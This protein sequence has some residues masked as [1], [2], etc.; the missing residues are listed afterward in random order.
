MTRLREFNLPH[1]VSITGFLIV[2]ALGIGVS[3]VLYSS[4]SG[5]FSIMSFFSPELARLKYSATPLEKTLRTTM[6]EYVK[7][8]AD[9][10]TICR[11]LDSGSG[12]LGYYESASPIIQRDC[13]QCHGKVP[14]VAG[15]GSLYT[16]ADVLPY[17]MTRGSPIRKLSLRAH[18]HLFGIGL[19]LLILT[20]LANRTSI[21]HFL[22]LTISISLFGLLATDILSQ[23]LAKLNDAFA[24]IVWISGLLLNISVVI[25]ILLVLR[26][27]WFGE[28]VE[29]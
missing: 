23:Y 13:S 25:S 9:I 3:G 18:V 8:E 4:G 21:P 6:R 14:T 15:V 16:Y 12:R 10:K 27:I 17:A 20:M 2:F 19:L 29:N 28:Q 5:R 11:W 7:S 24:Y 26:D 22:K 1:K